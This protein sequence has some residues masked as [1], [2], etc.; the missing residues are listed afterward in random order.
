[1]KNLLKHYF[2]LKF[3]G[4]AFNDIVTGEA[5]FYYEDCFGEIWMK[6]SR[7]SFFRVKAN[8]QS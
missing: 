4:F 6:N 5:V 7:W 8:H 3:R 1:M 2:S